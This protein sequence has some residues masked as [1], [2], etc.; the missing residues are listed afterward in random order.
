MIKVFIS[1]TCYDLKDIRDQLKRFISSFGCTPI[2][3]DQNDVFFDPDI[4]THTSCI[5][6]VSKCDMMLLIVGGRFGGEAVPEA[7]ER[8]SQDELSK[9]F[10]GKFDEYLGKKLFSIT[11]LEALKA[12]EIG[13]PVWTFIA[14][15]VY[16]EHK[17]YEKNKNIDIEYPSISKRET[18]KYIFEFID[19]I[20]KRRTGN[21]IF[22]FEYTRT[23][24]EILTRQFSG[25][26][27][28][29]LKTP[30]RINEISKN[31]EAVPET[32]LEMQ[33][34]IDKLF[35][36]VLKMSS[37]NISQTDNLSNQRSKYNRIL[38]VDDYPSNNESI[39][40]LFESKDVRFDIAINT[41]QGINFIIDNENKYDLIITDMGRGNEP[42]AG[43]T[44]I[45]RIKQLSINNTPPVIVF[46]SSR[47]I[48][49]YGRS[50]INLGAIATIHG[51]T[52]IIAAISGLLDDKNDK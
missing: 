29:G 19:F 28:K 52:H 31:A 25:L 42:D 23:I 27:E 38:W 15:N 47:A 24:E 17:I 16:A 46:T 3:S 4:H 50:A 44:L 37:E 26:L 13:I 11:Q 5:E 51:A 45:K 18:A 48:A 2:L 41:E 7:Y 20:R 49:R 14:H 35:N 1:S 9:I 6:E 40:D 36:L 39:I 34:K 32:V 30:V 10:N 8:L 33:D 12:I 22:S 21:N 43:L